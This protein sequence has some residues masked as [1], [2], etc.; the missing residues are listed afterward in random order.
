MSDMPVAALARV[1]GLL[2]G[3]VF[4]ALKF[5][6]RAKKAARKLKKGMIKGGMNRKLAGQLA[7][8]FEESVSIRRL[9]SQATGGDADFSS[10]FPFGR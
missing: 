10:I 9:M 7:S 6:R 2:I 3:L 8:Q 4:S 1:P 5:K